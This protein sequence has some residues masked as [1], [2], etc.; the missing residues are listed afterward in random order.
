[1]SQE[2]SL[3]LCLSKTQTNELS[4][5]QCDWET[6]FPR[7]SLSTETIIFI[8][9]TYSWEN[10]SKLCL[11]GEGL[12]ALSPWEQTNELSL[13]Q[14]HQEMPFEDHLVPET[15][16]LTLSPASLRSEQ[17]SWAFPS[18]TEKW[19]FQDHLTTKLLH[20]LESLSAGKWLEALSSWRMA[21]S[22]ASPRPENECVETSPV[23]LL[24][25]LFKTI[26]PLKTIVLT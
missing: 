18:I 20:R 19:P 23:S 11:L 15:I 8:W 4:L 26:F 25:S 2:N 6:A 9:S 17:M 14:C 5:P 3:K 1:M 24:N 7:P 22:S 13:P 12:E 10:G 21:Q 16:V